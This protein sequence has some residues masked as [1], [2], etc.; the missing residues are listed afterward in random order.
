[1]LIIFA[2]EGHLGERGRARLPM[3]GA[4]RLRGSMPPLSRR[5]AISPAP[6]GATI[7][8]GTAQCRE[9]LAQ[10]PS[11]RLPAIAPALNKATTPITTA[12]SQRKISAPSPGTP[13]LLSIIRR[14]LSTEVEAHSLKQTIRLQP[15][16]RVI[17]R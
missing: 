13:D 10:H 8:P 11:R 12:A 2:G 16:Q 9:I 1:L 17:S 15:R 5:C 4:A 6:T 3:A 7:A 14:G